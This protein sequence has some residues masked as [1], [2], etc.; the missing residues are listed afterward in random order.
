MWLTFDFSSRDLT[1]P[2]E[3]R[4]H[5]AQLVCQEQS[6]IKGIL[7]QMAHLEDL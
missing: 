2:V 4:D 3:L 7:E 6:E 1:A 5:V